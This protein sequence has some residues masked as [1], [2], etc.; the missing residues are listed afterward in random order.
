MFAEVFERSLEADVP[1]IYY[2]D[3]LKALWYAAKGDRATAMALSQA[4]ASLN[5][6][7]VRA[8]LHR[9]NQDETCARR[10]YARARRPM[11]N[12]PIETERSSIALSLLSDLT[13]R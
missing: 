2:T 5:Q 9:M 8:H 3:S 6:A 4:V 12:S 1:P 10:W 7:W 11:P 13:R